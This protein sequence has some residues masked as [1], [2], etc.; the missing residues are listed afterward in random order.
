MD[1]TSHG[2]FMSLMSW[3]I[4]D[5]RSQAFALSFPMEHLWSILGAPAGDLAGDHVTAQVSG[6]MCTPGRQ[7]DS[8]QLTWSFRPIRD[9]RCLAT[10]QSQSARDTWI[11]SRRK[12]RSNS[13]ENH[14]WGT[15]GDARTWVNASENLQNVEDTTA[16]QD[17]GWQQLWDQ[18]F[19]K[20]NQVTEQVF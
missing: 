11:H 16:G 15:A 2:W 10:D 5:N 4:W 6:C 1:R 9:E 12:H 20:Q 13:L 8:R 18:R 14:V 17:F 3:D 19:P 7:C